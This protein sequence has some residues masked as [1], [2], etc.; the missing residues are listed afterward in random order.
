MPSPCDSPETNQMVT[1]TL[2]RPLGETELHCDKCNIS[3]KKIETFKVHKENYCESRHANVEAIQ[4]A[5]A[6]KQRE[7]EEN[8]LLNKV[9]QRY[10]IV[11][12]SRSAGL[13]YSYQERTKNRTMLEPEDGSDWREKAYPCHDCKIGF[14]SKKH[15]AAHK[16]NY[17]I[18]RSGPGSPGSNSPRSTSPTNLQNNHLLQA[19]MMLRYS[20]FTITV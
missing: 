17:C 13:I 8:K 6:E 16:M 3:F 19:V 14:E 4:A 7:R 15:Y 12:N 20:I 5:R 18:N 11:D 9:N 1:G 10:I 2:G